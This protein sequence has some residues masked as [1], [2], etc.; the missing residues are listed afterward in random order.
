MI[1]PPPGHKSI[2]SQNRK[3]NRGAKPTLFDPDPF[4]RHYASR[5]DGAYDC[6]DRIILNGYFPLAQSPGGFRS[7]WRLLYGS[8]DLLDNAHLMRMAGRFSRRLRAWA[9]K[10]DVPVVDCDRGERKHDVAEQYLPSDPNRLGIFCVL[11]GRAP[12][13]VWDVRRFGETGID[14]RHKKAQPYVN[15]Y[16][17]HIL[18]PEWGWLTI[19]LCGHPPFTAQIFLNGHEYV[20]RRARK[21]KINFT[22]EGNCFTETS[23]AAGL[24]QVADT[25]RSHDAIGR[26]KQVCE[27]WIYS[28]C[29]CFALD[30]DDQQ[31]TGFRYAYS[32]YQAEYSRNL[33]FHDGRGMDHVFQGLIDR[34][35]APLDI[36]AVKTIF[37]FRQRHRRYR[38]K[39]SP[40]YE[41]VVERPEY[42]LTVFK[43]HCGRLT[44]KIYTKGERVLRIEAI[45]HNTVDL[46]CGRQLDRFPDMIARLTAILHRFLEVLHCVDLTWIGDGT[47]DQLPE[48]SQIGRTRVG[49][50]DMN[51]PRTRAVMEAVISLSSSPQGFAIR[52][53]AA[54]VAEI[55]GLPYHPRQA[56][57]DLK[58][59][60]G[61]SLVRRIEH[62]RCWEATAEGL[63]TMAGLVV[64]REKVIKPL[65]AGI[66]EPP[67]C[68]KPK[69]HGDV[70][71]HYE[72]IR[73]EVYSLFQTLRIAI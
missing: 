45:A 20:A 19:K 3:R 49:G 62:T 37:G 69:D 15:H 44:L 26:L 30:L 8:D 71:S 54:R 73:A 34:T 33:V 39:E 41:V 42:D 53:L 68:P 18:D 47:L 23:N 25:L 32:V 50:V 64:L 63:R 2:P 12:F 13:P 35:R 17:F 38:K 7:W 51:R 10:N 58:K 70:E 14:I 52:A 31:R 27:R 9:S 46:R 40:R 43:V 65:L 11:V 55:T 61:K 59:L 72:A 36:R 4:S 16:S 28:A 6:V 60:R 22:K 29:L 21:E 67:R 66:A 57:Y 24:S 56:A 48:P 5:L 1:L